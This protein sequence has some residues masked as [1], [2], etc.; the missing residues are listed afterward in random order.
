MLPSLGFVR[1][2]ALSVVMPRMNENPAG[3]DLA[4][5]GESGLPHL[6]HQATVVVPCIPTSVFNRMSPIVLP[7]WVAGAVIRL[8]INLSSDNGAYAAPLMM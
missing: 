8:P 6:S 3:S 7:T 2:P 4:R 5:F 1:L